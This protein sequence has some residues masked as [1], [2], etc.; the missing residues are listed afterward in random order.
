MTK[1]ACLAVVMALARMEGVFVMKAT[2]G[3]TAVN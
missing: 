1:R 3:K 2:V